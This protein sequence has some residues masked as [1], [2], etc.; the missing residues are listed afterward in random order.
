[1]AG[2]VVKRRGALALLG[3]LNRHLI[4]GCDRDFS[5]SKRSEQKSVVNVQSLSH[6]LGIRGRPV[7]T[8]GNYPVQ[9]AV[10][11]SATPDP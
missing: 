4:P 11:V 8:P 9:G 6:A 1:M 10:G 2:P 3:K 5:T 7:R